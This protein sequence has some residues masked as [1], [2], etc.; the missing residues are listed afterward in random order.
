MKVLLYGN[1][2]TRAI[3]Q[4]IHHPDIEIKSITCHSTSLTKKEFTTEIKSADIII[5]QPIL[6][7]YRGKE[8]LSTNYVIKNANQN[9]N[10]ILFPSLMVGNIYYF[11]SISDQRVN[12]ASA[13]AFAHKNLLDYYTQGGSDINYFI[14]NF[15]TN[16]NLL[17]RKQLESNAD[18]VIGEL[19]RRED[20][21]IKEHG[22]PFIRMSSFI[23]NNWKNNLLFY[24]SNH[25]TLHLYQYLA[26]QIC[27]KIGLSFDSID[28]KQDPQQKACR[29][30]LYSC[31]E[32]IVKFDLTKC[33]PPKLMFADKPDAETTRDYIESIFSILKAY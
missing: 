5:T 18:N 30:I 7:N 20:E 21:A 11:D 26:Q 4:I 6:Q 8:Y 28:L 33:L 31:L 13:T 12:R 24:T 22:L 15:V 1:C 27:K 32:N 19:I 9:T 10:I 3:S 23:K 17:T 2:Q 14:K 25:G 29:L 16:K